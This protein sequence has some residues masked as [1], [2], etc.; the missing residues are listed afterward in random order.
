M[1]L[2]TLQRVYYPCQ[3]ERIS[4]PLK[5][6]SKN[7]TD[8]GGRAAME[9]IFEIAKGTNKFGDNLL[10]SRQIVQWYGIVR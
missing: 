3:N 9:G 6:L 8:W 1:L 4:N 10:T 7:N 2:E 5:T